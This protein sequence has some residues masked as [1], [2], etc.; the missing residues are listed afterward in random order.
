MPEGTVKWFNPHKGFGFITSTDGTEIF[1]HKSDVDYI[2]YRDHLQEG[3]KVS[4]E[5]QDSPKGKK[6]IKVHTE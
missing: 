2:G 6:A 5:V 1:V 3:M 4:F